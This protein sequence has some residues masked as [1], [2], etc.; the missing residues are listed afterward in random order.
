MGIN[1][2]KTGLEDNLLSWETK[3]T[4][5]K[6]SE[7]INNNLKIGGMFVVSGEFAKEHERANSNLPA[8]EQ[9]K[10]IQKEDWIKACEYLDDVLTAEN[11]QKLL[12]KLKKNALQLALNIPKSSEFKL[13]L[14]PVN[15]QGE[16]WSDEELA[17][18][19]AFQYMFKL[20]TGETFWPG[21]LNRASW[22]DLL[23]IE[24][25]QKCSRRIEVDPR[26][27]GAVYGEMRKAIIEQFKIW[28]DLFDLP[29]SEDI[30]NIK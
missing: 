12:I 18:N 28:M 29:V 3:V 19:A 2:T 4:S 10:P 23:P 21:A 27:P 15:D 16:V 7:P 13:V 20:D 6:V 9:P 1:E 24:I 25:Q 8:T 17:N 11:L 22:N 5:N 14:M 26:N 30:N